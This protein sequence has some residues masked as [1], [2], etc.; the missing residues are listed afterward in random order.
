M[1][2]TGTEILLKSS[3]QQYGCVSRASTGERLEGKRSPASRG[4]SAEPHQAAVAQVS[5]DETGFLVEGQLA[6]RI[7]GAGVT[8]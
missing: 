4:K 6:R 8:V 7:P 2:W 3:S 5:S 1:A